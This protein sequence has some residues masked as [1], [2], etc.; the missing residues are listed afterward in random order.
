MKRLRSG[1]KMFVQSLRC[2]EKMV[3]GSA[4]VAAMPEKVPKNYFMLNNYTVSSPRNF[5]WFSWRAPERLALTHEIKLLGEKPLIEPTP[6]ILARVALPGGL[7]ALA[8]PTN[9]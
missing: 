5:R 1:G 3:P 6:F 4:T 8:D 7:S 2:A 9:I